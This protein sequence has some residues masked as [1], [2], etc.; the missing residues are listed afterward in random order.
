MNIFL[1]ML[2]LFLVQIPGREI[3]AIKGMSTV[4]VPDT[5]C[6]ISLQGVHTSLRF[7]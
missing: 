3:A 7:L 5:Y 2:N 1:P 4:E 6:Q